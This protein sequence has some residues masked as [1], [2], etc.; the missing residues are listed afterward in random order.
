MKKLAIH[1]SKSGFHPR[2]VAYCKENQIPYKEVNCYAN[3]LIEQLQDCYALMWHFSQSNFKD[4]IIAKKI[5]FA[6]EH[7]GFKVFPDFNTAWHFDDKVA[8]KYLLEGIG[9]PIVN[10]YVFYDKNEA[11]EWIQN[12]AFPKV[13][14]LRGGAG[15]ANVKLI[16]NRKAAIKWIALSF[17][18]GVKSNDK[19]SAV[20]EIWRKFRLGKVKFKEVIKRFTRLLI[21][22]PFDKVNPKEWGYVYFQDFIP[23]NESDTRIIVVGNKAFGLIRYVRA[24]DFR[25]SGSGVFNYEKTLF[26]K[27]AIREAFEVNNKLALQVGVYDFVFDKNNSPLIVELS[28]GFSANA[29]DYCPGY[30]DDK[31][32]WYD[33]IFN[34]Q[35]WMVD[36]IKK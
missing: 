4:R 17:G 1:Q 15:S 24:N 3:D 27:D 6:L 33:G 31:L 20:K 34:P 9:A 12:T 11:L 7:T 21:S 14:K 8:Q 16:K 25:A 23:D 19:K 36:L 13:A 35:G 29:Y 28:Y 10:S 32:T 26:N 22:T 5:L 18:K 30:W 2:W